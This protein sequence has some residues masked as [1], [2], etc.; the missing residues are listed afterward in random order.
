MTRKGLTGIP[1]CIMYDDF[2]TP[3]NAAQGR[4]NMKDNVLKNYPPYK[5]FFSVSICDRKLIHFLSA[6]TDNLEQ[7]NKYRMV[8]CNAQKNIVRLEFLRLNINYE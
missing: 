4:G 6:S 8:Y 3:I 5:G 7:R 2:T 1:D